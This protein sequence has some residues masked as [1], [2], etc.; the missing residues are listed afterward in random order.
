MGKK[1][2]G[3]D[4]VPTDNAFLGLKNEQRA[5]LLPKRMNHWIS[6]DRRSNL[7][8]YHEGSAT[9][10]PNNARIRNYEIMCWKSAMV[11][12][13]YHRGKFKNMVLFLRDFFYT[14]LIRT[15]LPIAPDGCVLGRC[16]QIYN[17][18]L[19]VGVWLDKEVGLILSRGFTQD[20][21]KLDKKINSTAEQ[22]IDIHRFR[23]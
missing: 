15:M 18:R 21:M 8:K 20:R 22:C 1:S 13:V 6:L 14:R 9:I 2:C 16:I 12:T 10:A 4:L 5:Y 7:A 11:Y 23:K 17:C 3:F 19:L